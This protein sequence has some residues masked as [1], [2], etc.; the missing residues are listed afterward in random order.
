MTYAD[1]SSYA[2]GWACGQPHGNGVLSARVPA[3]NAAGLTPLLASTAAVSVAGWPTQRYEGEWQAG[4][5][6]GTGELQ[7]ANGAVFEGEVANGLPHGEGSLRFT[8][9]V[10]DGQASVTAAG[11]WAAGALH[12]HG[13]W[14]LEAPREAEVYEGGFLRGLREGHAV[15]QLR[16]GSHVEGEYRGG[17]RNGVATVRY[18]DR[19]LYSG[20]FVADA[21]QGKGTLVHANGDVY[22]GLWE[23]DRPHGAGT[24]RRGATGVEERG[25]WV[26]G[27]R[28]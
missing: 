5:P 25:S 22:V 17:R 9:A 1:G 28:A 11:S 12:G 2:G 4:A 10:P 20:K 26:N 21:R 8:A 18:A 27:V 23:A 24:L 19:A 7:Y 16:D 3:D 14:R 15:A 13:T 6:T